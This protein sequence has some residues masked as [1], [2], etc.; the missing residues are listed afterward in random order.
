[1]YVFE[2]VVLDVEEGVYEFGEEVV[3][4][5]LTVVFAQLQALL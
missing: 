1:M 5:Y 3:E 4:L 2:S